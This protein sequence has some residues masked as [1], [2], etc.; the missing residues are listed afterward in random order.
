MKS[1]DVKTGEIT[2]EKRGVEFGVLLNLIYPTPIIKS[3]VYDFTR[4]NYTE[5]ITE[6]SDG[7]R[8]CM[9]AKRDEPRKVTIQQKY[10][11]LGITVEGEKKEIPETGLEILFAQKGGEHYEPVLKIM[12]DDKTFLPINLPQERQNNETK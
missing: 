7:I 10:R 12:P 4:A 5:Y 6:D 3:G 11:V 1:V 9:T 2:T 8:Y